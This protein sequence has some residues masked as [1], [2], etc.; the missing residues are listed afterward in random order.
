MKKIALLLATC[1]ALAM[2]GCASNPLS[3]LVSEETKAPVSTEPAASSSESAPP[4]PENSPTAEETEISLGKKATIGDWKICAK[5]AAVKN[6]IKNDNYRYY[7]PSKGNTFIVISLSVRNTGKKMEEFLP[8]VGYK[9]KMVSATLFYEDE[10]EYSPT[11]LLSYDKDI[12]T[13]KIQP[14]TTKKG[15]L[16]FDVPK[17]VGKAKK[18]LKLKFSTQSGSVIYYLK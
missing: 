7:E 15:I 4:A 11:E 12:T 16:V 18:K 3:D 14:L 13:E 5:S 17:K 2:T 8:R 6:K 9:D 10:Y 1:T